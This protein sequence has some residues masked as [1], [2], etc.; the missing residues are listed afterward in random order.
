[1]P[2]RT[3]PLVMGEEHLPP[4]VR[5]FLKEADRR[6][7]HF[8]E[9][10]GVPGFV[11]SD[12][13]SVYKAL[14][15]LERSD[16]VAGRWF[17]EWGS[18]LGV[19]SCLATILG[20]DAWGIEEKECL[21]KAARLLA[22]RFELPTEFA[23]GNFVPRQAEALLNQQRGFAWLGSAARC[24][25]EAAGVNLDEFDLVFAYP[26]PDEERLVIDLFEGYASAGALLLTHH[27][28]GDLRLCR[29]VSRAAE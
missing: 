13:G 11:T 12:Y 28:D 16:L 19:V 21:V 29:K 17:C 26:W 22:A 18:G 2:L 3:V 7:D 9:E 24:G 5:R 14:R 8:R 27:V 25:Y 1:M 20:F 6:I 10:H 23:R 4:D 15:Y